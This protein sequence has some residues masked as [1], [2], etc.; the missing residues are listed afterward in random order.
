MLEREPV[1]GGVPRH[2]GHPPFGLREFRRPM[3]GPAYA[4]ALVRAGGRGGRRGSFTRV[5]VAALLP[6]PRLQLSTPDGTGELAARAVLLATGARE[7]PPRRAPRSAAPGP[8][9]C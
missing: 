1:A 3:F 2:C 5:T 8:R 6:G 4:R 7:I 9:A